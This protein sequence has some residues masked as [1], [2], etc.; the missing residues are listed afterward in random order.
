MW[1]VG[2]LFN[3]NGM[4]T[5]CWEAAHALAEAG[6]NVVLVC[7]S[8]VVFPGSTSVPVLRIEAPALRTVGEK[9]FANGGLLSRHGPRVMRS[10]VHVLEAQGHEVTRILLN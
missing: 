8:D 1:L 2:Y 9:L 10:A 5:W 3:N 7:A 6:E 4:G